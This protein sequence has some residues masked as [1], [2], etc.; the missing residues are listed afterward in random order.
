MSSEVDAPG[1]GWRR[2][3]VL[4]AWGAL[5]SFA[6]PMLISLSFEPFLAA[7]AAPF[8]IG[9]LV[10]ARW[11]RAGVITLGVVSLAVLASSVPFLLDPLTHPESIVDFL[12]L[13][14]FAISTVLG[15]V[16]AVPSYREAPPSPPSSRPARALAFAAVAIFLVAAVV[17]VIAFLGVD[18]EAA[19]TGDVP[20][21]AEDLEYVPGTLTAG[22]GTVS[23]VMT[24][25]DGTRHTFTIDALDV[26]LSVPPNTTQ[27]VSFA[28]PAGT[29]TFYCRPHA[30]TMEGTLTVE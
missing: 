15:V 9:L 22:A 11:P 3:Q 25:R 12:P 14:L 2:L 19:E 29:Y 28:A 18:S 16:A 7:M 13:A 5:I 21:A 10:M 6:A 26:D 30:D 24:N 8:V 1:F 20:L 23:V 17:S 27:R 4:A